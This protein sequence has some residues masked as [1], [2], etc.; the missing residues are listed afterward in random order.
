[1][2]NPGC[3]A[4]GFIALVEP[5]IK[6]NILS[7]NVNLSAFSLTGY[8]GGGKK[9]IAEYEGE[10]DFL[11]N[12]PRTYGITQNHKHLKEM[13]KVCNLNSAPVFC[14][15]V[16][17]YYSGMEVTIPLF[18]KDIQGSVQ[19]I[20]QIYKEYYKVGLVKFFEESENGFLSANI[21]ANRDDMLVGV[22]GNEERFTLVARFDNL[23]KGASGAAIQNMNILMGINEDTGLNVK[24]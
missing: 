6:N 9:M 20:K 14:P 4:S 17:P 23:G 19:D 1:M 7:S 3:H 13:V 10:R 24:E 15:I 2:A 16:A 18:K 5:L 8:S 22:F 12:A 21:M 11:L